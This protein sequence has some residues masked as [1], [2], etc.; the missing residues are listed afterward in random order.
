MMMTTTVL[1]CEQPSYHLKPSRST[2]NK[3]LTHRSE[4]ATRAVYGVVARPRL[5]LLV[6]TGFPTSII[7]CHRAKNIKLDT[8][9]ERLAIESTKPELSAIHSSFLEETL[10]YRQILH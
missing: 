8:Q 9:P 3:Y 4:H 6:G 2:N 1:C 10:R 7:S 5:S